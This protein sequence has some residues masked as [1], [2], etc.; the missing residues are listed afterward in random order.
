MLDALNDTHES[1]VAGVRMSVNIEPSRGKYATYHLWVNGKRVLTKRF[2]PRA[3][4][5]K[6][7]PF[8]G[9]GGVAEAVFRLAARS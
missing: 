1:N 5:Q 9:A 3:D 2:S 8:G 6:T 7:H 4:N